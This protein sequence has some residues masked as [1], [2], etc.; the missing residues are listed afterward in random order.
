S[1]SSGKRSRRRATIVPFPTPEG[2]ATTRSKSGAA[3]DLG[4]AEEAFALVAPEPAQSAALA[5]VELLH[6]AA[7]L[8]LADTRERLQHADDLELRERVVARALVAQV[9]E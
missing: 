9:T 4:V 2:P 6:D 7:R 1:Q 8:H 5:D 3:G